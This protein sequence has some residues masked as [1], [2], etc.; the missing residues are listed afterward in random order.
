M[1][2]SHGLSWNISSQAVTANLASSAFE[3]FKEQS[4]NRWGRVY[5]LGVVHAL[6]TAAASKASRNARIECFSSTQ[7]IAIRSCNV[8]T[9]AV[10]GQRTQLLGGRGCVVAVTYA[11]LVMLLRTDLRRTHLLQGVLSVLLTTVRV[12]CDKRKQADLCTA[13]SAAFGVQSQS[14]DF[15]ITAT[16]SLPCCIMHSPTRFELLLTH[17]TS[18]SLLSLFFNHSL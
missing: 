12:W 8:A 1:K 18:R 11:Y 14:T 16:H 4:P 6:F 13:V 7:Y 2:L 5:M 9:V 3:G 10:Y 17:D 15:K